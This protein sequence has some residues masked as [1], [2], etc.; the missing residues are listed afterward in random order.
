MNARTEAI[1]THRGLTDVFARRADAD[2]EMFCRGRAADS[3]ATGPEGAGERQ[4]LEPDATARG[5]DDCGGPATTGGVHH[6]HARVVGLPY[7]NSDGT[8]RRDAVSGLRRWERVYLSHRPDNPVD[9]NAVEVSRAG[10]RRQLGFLP[11]ALAAD[12]VAAAREGTRFLA[13]VADVSASPP[14]ELIAAAPVRA[15]LLVLALEDGAPVS[16]ARRYLLDL[17]NRR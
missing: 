3:F 4:E 12:I 15:E 11:A 10:D 7:P 1:M 5:V 17:M 16:A 13:V 8:S 6:F 14:G 2:W 9:L